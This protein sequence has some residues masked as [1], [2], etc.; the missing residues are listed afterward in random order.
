[1]IDDTQQDAHIYVEST[2]NVQQGPSQR[3]TWYPGLPNTYNILMIKNMEGPPVRA[4]A[5]MTSLTRY[6]ASRR[7]S[8]SVTSLGTCR[9]T[10]HRNQSHYSHVEA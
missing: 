10:P 5:I 1:M 7:A 6:L 9:P 2:L 8:L 4:A 3:D